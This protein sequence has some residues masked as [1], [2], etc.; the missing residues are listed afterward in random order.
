MIRPSFSLVAVLLLL[1]M[2][3][4]LKAAADSD[5]KAPTYPTEI[6]PKAPIGFEVAA[7]SPDGSKLVTGSYDGAIQLWD[8]PSGRLIRKFERHSKNVTSVVFVANG[9]Q[10]LSASEDMT[11]KLWD[12]A[13]GRLLKTIT[14][15]SPAECGGI[16][17]CRRTARA[18]SH[19]RASPQLLIL[20]S[21]RSS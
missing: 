5:P 12:A 16:S 17:S 4:P 8:R 11:I 14:L 13:S 10:L 20:A 19:P 18:R 6:V 3:S 15:N 21:R 1:T 2:S 7:L 9:S